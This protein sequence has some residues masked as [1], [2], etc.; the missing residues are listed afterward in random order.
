MEKR[1]GWVWAG[2]L[3]M[4]AGLFVWLA[5]PRLGGPLS[6]QAQGRIIA[7]EV[8]EDASSKASPLYRARVS[9]TAQGDAC[10]SLVR[11]PQS[12][13][14]IGQ[15][16]TVRYDPENPAAARLLEP[17]ILPW[18]GGCLTAAGA[19]MAAWNGWTGLRCKGRSGKEQGDGAVV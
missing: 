15:Q 18:I 19:G 13:Y 4:A 9:F 10:E 17:I 3:L 16:V 5:G 11:I 8:D 6:A 1:K 14:T 7:I 12:V 2:I